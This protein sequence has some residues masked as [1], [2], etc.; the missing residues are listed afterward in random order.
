MSIV[1]SINGGLVFVNNGGGIF[2]NF[3]PPFI[4]LTIIDIRCNNKQLINYI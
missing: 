4:E 1:N 3:D 2:T